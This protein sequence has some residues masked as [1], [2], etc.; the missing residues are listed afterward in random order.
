MALKY[1]KIAKKKNRSTKFLAFRI[2]PKKYSKKCKE[3][4][5]SKKKNIVIIGAHASGKSKELNKIIKQSSLIF[6]KNKAIVLKAQEPLSDW[7]NNITNQDKQELLLNQEL[8]EEEKI[9]IENNINKSYV[10]AMTLINKSK[11]AIIYIDDIDLLSGRK[12]EIV[13]DILKVCKIA[14][15]TAKNEQDINKSIYY[16]LQ[17]KGMQL[18]SLD[19]STSYDATNILFVMFVLAMLATGQHEL[20]LLVMAGRYT[21]KGTQKK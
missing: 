5:V 7:Y 12:V 10:K 19:S 3:I 11:N 13:K 21:L 4:Y 20:A 1:F 9:T 8:S 15:V 14:V 17:K 2:K 18:L 16:L 6:S